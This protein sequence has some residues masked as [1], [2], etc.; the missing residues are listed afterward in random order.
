MQ[1]PC[2]HTQPDPTSPR[3]VLQ[4]RSP[5]SRRHGSRA[6]VTTGELLG[7]SGQ[8]FSFSGHC[9]SL[10]FCSLEVLF[11]PRPSQPRPEKT[12][13]EN[14]TMAVYSLLTN[15]SSFLLQVNLCQTFAAVCRPWDGRAREG[16]RAVADDAPRIA[17]KRALASLQPPG[18]S[19][20]A[21]LRGFGT[22]FL[23]TPRRLAASPEYSPHY[24]HSRCKTPRPGSGT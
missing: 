10:Y 23:T 1:S 18:W 17:T 12:L 21:G 15:I 7:G 19:A 11:Q 4:L 5:E 16:Q 20:E 3:P 8:V 6:A 14:R 22:W 24:R 13:Q 9:Y 2:A